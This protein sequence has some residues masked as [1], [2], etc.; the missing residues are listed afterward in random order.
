MIRLQAVRLHICDGVY[1]RTRF[2]VRGQKSCHPG[3]MAEADSGSS[4][5][6]TLD[7]SVMIRRP[8]RRVFALLADVQDAEP[9]PRRAVVRMENPS[10]P[11]AVGTRWHEAV[12]FAPGCWLGIESIVTELEPPERLGMDFSTRWFGGHPTYDIEPTQEGCVLLHR[13]TLRPRA[14]LPWLPAVIA[15]RLRSHLVERL[16]DIRDLLESGA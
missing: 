1:L 8:P 6:R 3:R 11:T 16:A 13:E 15:P 2:G 14:L 10:G 5:I 9:L 7:L 4:S 12:R